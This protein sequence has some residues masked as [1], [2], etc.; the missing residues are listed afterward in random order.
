MSI[1]MLSS[2]TMKTFLELLICSLISQDECSNIN[3]L[4]HFNGN[5]I[6]RLLHEKVNGSLFKQ[7]IF[8]KP[9]ERNFGLR[10]DFS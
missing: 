8:R 7:M 2:E 5:G 6:L 10:A 9:F 4:F 3:E 1:Q